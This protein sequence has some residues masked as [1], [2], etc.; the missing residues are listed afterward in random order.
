MNISSLKWS[1][2]CLCLFS[3]CWIPSW[4]A[5]PVLHWNFDESEG[6]EVFDTALQADHGLIL[7][8]P[9]AGDVTREVG[10]FGKAAS[11]NPTNIPQDWNPVTIESQS[12]GSDF[13]IREYP[14][15]AVVSLFEWEADFGIGFWFRR[16]EVMNPNS[17]L[18]ILTFGRAMTIGVS[19]TTT[20]EGIKGTLSWDYTWD[21]FSQTTTT[22]PDSFQVEEWNHFIL[23]RVGSLSRIYRNGD[24]VGETDL[25]SVFPAGEYDTDPELADKSLV[26]GGK[27]DWFHIEPFDLDEFWI[28]EGI[29]NP[30]QM[31]SLIRE[32]TLPE[33]GIRIQKVALDGTKLSIQFQAP[34]AIPAS[35][36]LVEGSSHLDT[37][38][39]NLTSQ[40]Q[41]SEIQPA[42]GNYLAEIDVS[43]KGLFFFVKISILE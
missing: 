35:G 21:G 11:F 26:L 42:S 30:D 41:I 23:Q 36:W 37:F 12:V 17:G 1:S 43:G 25:L 20:T 40:T 4:A 38:P 27:L 22:P 7:N 29:L 31:K 18:Q 9:I 8:S 10:I 39:E 24:L 15:N 32:N 16:S 5:I 3:V 14:I 2:L 28:W 19:L 33:A 13:S 6:L 34:P